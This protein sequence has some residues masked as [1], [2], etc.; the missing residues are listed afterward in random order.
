MTK[1]FRQQ[2]KTE[3]AVAIAQGKSVDLWARVNHVPRSTAYRWAGHPDVQATSE[4]CRR[5][6]QNRALRKMANRAYWASYHVAALARDAESEHVQLRALR[7]IVSGA[8][9]MSKLPV[10]K[11]RMSAIEEELHDSIENARPSPTEVPC[12]L[13][14]TGDKLPK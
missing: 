7:S 10:L 14:G 5:R 11:R 3:L 2:K 9:A 1:K 12:S 8:N 6:A 13:M 4:A